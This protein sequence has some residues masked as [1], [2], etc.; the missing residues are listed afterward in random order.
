MIRDE[1]LPNRFSS[2]LTRSLGKGYPKLCKAWSSSLR[3]IVPELSLAAGNPRQVSSRSVILRFTHNTYRSNRK[4]ILCQSLIYA[5]RPSNS[6]KLYDDSRGRISKYCPAYRSSSG[7]QAAHLMKPLRSLSKIP[8][9]TGNLPIS[10]VSNS[11]RCL[12][13]FE[14]LLISYPVRKKGTC[15]FQIDQL[16][17]PHDLT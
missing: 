14:D 10:H 9:V 3:S 5:H 15:P 6:L 2:F 1:Y 8:A 16:T 11:P 4:K 17:S 13:P 12:P 7:G